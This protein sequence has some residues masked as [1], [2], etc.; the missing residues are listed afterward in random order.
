MQPN[1][2]KS[3]DGRRFCHWDERQSA[4]RGAVQVGRLILQNLF[5]GHGAS[6]T[7]QNNDGL[8]PLDFALEVGRD[9]LPGQLVDHAKNATA[10][11]GDE[12]TQL[13]LGVQGKSMELTNPNMARTR[14]H[15]TWLG[16]LKLRTPTG[17]LRCIER[18]GR[19]ARI[20]HTWSSSMTGTRQPRTLTGPLP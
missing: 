12:S 13:G 2:R 17:T 10:Q 3:D 8:T 19:K 20:T 11:D 5:I 16:P 1:E 18:C 4:A 7:A 15:K 9:D 14:Q 6:V